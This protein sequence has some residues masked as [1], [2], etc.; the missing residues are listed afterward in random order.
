MTITFASDNPVK[1]IT[2]FLFAAGLLCAESRLNRYAVV[3]ADPPLAVEAGSQK[4]LRTTAASDGRRKIESAQ[5]ELRGALAERNLREI[6][7][8]QTLLN[9]V[10]VKATEEE[11]AA[12]RTVPGV[13]AV[14][15]MRKFQ[16]HLFTALDLMNVPAAWNVIGGAQNAGTGVKIGVIDSGIDQ[17][18][19]GFQDESLM[20]PAG[21]PKCQSPGDCAYTNK[22]VIVARSYVDKLSLE[23]GDD[24]L[25]TRPDDFSPRDRVGHG[26]AV[27]MAAAGVRNTGPLGTITGVAPKAF[28]GNYKVFGSPGV[29]DA[30]FE[31]VV[32]MA[33]E[34]AATDGMDIVTISVG[35][36]ALCG[37]NNTAA[38]CGNDVDVYNAAVNNAVRMGMTVVLSAGN[39]GDVGYKLPSLGSIHSPGTAPAAITV[40]AT[41]NSHDFF[42]SVTVAA[43]TTLSRINAL[44]GNGPK[45]AGKLTAPLRDVSKLGKDGLA[46][47]PLTNG[48]LNGAIALILRGTCLR[49]QK[50][51]FAQKAGA[52]G[53]IIYQPEN[54]DSVFQM[55]GME[56]TGIPAVLV[57]NTGGV[58]LKNLVASSPDKLVTLDPALVMLNDPGYDVVS[59]FSSHGPSIGESAIKP[60]LVAVG[61][62]LYTATQKYDPNGDMYDPSGYTS[63]EG[64]SFAAPLVAGAA[65]LVKQRNPGFTPGQIKSAVV[66][67]ASDKVDD[68][69]ANNNLIGA[70]I[71]GM[72]AGKLDAG[73]AVKT[74]VTVEP[75]TLSFGVVG[76]ALPSQTLTI[77]NTGSASLTLTL[78]VKPSDNDANA[79]V[80]LSVSTLSLVPG[81]SGAVTV[82]MTGTKPLPGSYEGVVTVLGGAVPLHIPY[83]Y[84]VGDGVPYSYL[85]LTGDG[86]VRDVGAKLT[87]TFKILDQFGVPV[88]QVPVKFQ[89][90]LGGGTLTGGIANPSTDELGVAQAKV[91]VGQQPGDQEFT[92]T[93]AGFTVS[94][95]GTARLK[96]AIQAGAVVNA[97]SLQVGQG[98]A[99]GSYISIYGKGLSESTRA[100]NTPYLPVSLAG[101]S[102]SFDVQAKKISVPARVQFVSDGQ[103]NVQIPWELQ[104]QTSALMKVS[105]GDSSS[106]VYTVPL[107]DYS[108]A[109][110]EYTEASGGRVLAAA[111]DESFILLSSANPAKKGRIAQ[112]YMNGLGPVD[113]APASGEPAPGQVLA[114]TKTLP[115]VTVAGKNADVQFSGLAPLYV[116]LYQLNIVVPADTPSGIQ[117]VVVS[118]GGVVSKT[119]NLPIQ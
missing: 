1:I 9:A 12:L 59:F 90:T 2:L 76:T 57:G 24:P 106:T 36:A 119:T 92:A 41:D 71:T 37:P 102:V 52:L 13:I 17:T 48:S 45:P 4:E 18:H 35:S 50:V 68:Y 58:A 40:G 110:F 33:M 72:G 62:G 46:C 113:K 89:S 84:L 95:D 3:L 31:D 27:A 38:L 14:R 53:V 94:F 30:T 26:T 97:A 117:P 60:E 29:N 61:T 115:T 54:D 32:M 69:D 81:Q 75:S 107:K 11:A 118:V 111:L 8:M 19:P 80:A 49:D 39:A 20:V 34:A 66:N 88:G 112:I 10:F 64:T 56:N 109:A 70:R 82:R 7:S 6:G 73:A 65:A 116:G 44:F 15:E 74:N 86:F 22:K 43:P 47:A 99:P 83:L 96:P 77:R 91:V 104:G 5:G 23:F 42:Q 114:R 103:V 21:F 98:L 79:K 16:R 25:D 78:A 100:A 51:N 101:V 87:L 55:K 108:P 67:T 105:I 93:A 63:A 28:L 85:T